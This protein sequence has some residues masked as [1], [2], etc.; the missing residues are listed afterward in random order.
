MYPPSSASIG[1]LAILSATVVS[2]SLH[3]EGSIRPLRSAIPRATKAN[4]PMTKLIWDQFKLKNVMIR[5]EMD[6]SICTVS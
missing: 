6:D 2:S 1:V 3:R 4:S 5:N